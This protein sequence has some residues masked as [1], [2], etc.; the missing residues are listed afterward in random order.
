M[1]CP[2]GFSC[3]F[4][5]VVSRAKIKID[6]WV[7]IGS[8]MDLPNSMLGL[9]LGLKIELFDI[10]LLSCQCYST[11]IKVTFKQFFKNVD[12]WVQIGYQL[13]SNELTFEVQVRLKFGP[14]YRDTGFFLLQHFPRYLFSQENTLN[15]IF[16]ILRYF[17][18]KFGW[19]L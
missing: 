11:L 15:L 3:L 18:L 7:Q 1:W 17:T 2:H 13:G 5:G 12:F 14:K 10:S 9:K 16:Y 8:K 4:T 6:L 19:L